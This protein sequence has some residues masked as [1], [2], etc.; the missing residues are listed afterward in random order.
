[1]TTGDGFEDSGVCSEWLTEAMA[2]N[3][4]VMKEINLPA[5]TN[6][7][8]LAKVGQE[9]TE[10]EPILVFQNAYDEED[11]NLLLKTLNNDDDAVSEIGRNTIK[12]K[13]TGI[14]SDIKIYRTVKMSYH[15]H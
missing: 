3:I 11:A 1:M 12:S 8:Y 2:S 9:I 6:V 14:I 10:G 4:V 13:V 15:N 7:L 5:S